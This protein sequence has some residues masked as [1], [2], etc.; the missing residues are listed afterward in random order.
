MALN[1]TPNRTVK[2]ADTIFEMIRYLRKSDGSTVTEIAEMVGI[3]E[4]TAH[5][6]LATLLE[7]EYVVKDGPQYELS[8]KPLDNGMIVKNDMDLTDVARQVID[9]VADE[10]GEVTWI[11]I[12][13]HGRAVYLM[14]SAG[15]QAV[16]TRGRVGK[17]TPMHDIATGKAILA[18]LPKDRVDAIID[19]YG[20]PGQT[21]H[22]ITSREQLQDELEKIRERGFA[23]N[24]GET[25]NTVF[26]VA[27]PIFQDEEVQG[28][29]GIAGPKNRLSGEQ[30]TE[31]LPNI[32][33]EAADSIELELTYQ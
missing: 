17:R 33:C 18:N 26:A 10:T 25:I 30:F 16:R 9:Q 15:D 21:E 31:E 28:A 24:K 6:Y 27:S 3:A 13:E 29:I 1:D 23:T 14:K 5:T 12:E 19:H 32:V 4:S 11:V 7:H 2:T 8:L 20:L 22:T